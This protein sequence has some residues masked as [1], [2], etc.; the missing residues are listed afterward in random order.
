M[1]LIKKKS[2]V[3]DE[4]PTSSMADIAF[5]LL[6]FFLVTTIFDRDQGLQVVLPE[7][8]DAEIDVPPDNLLFL[9]VQ[10]NGSIVVRRGESPQTQTITH[11]QVQG[12]VRQAL[13]ANPEVIAAV[14]THPEARYEDMT[15]V[16]DGIQLAGARRFVLQQLQD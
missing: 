2:K 11:R 8:E 5:L 1:P 14:Q 4:I 6:I 9:L 7:R 13:Q 16:L 12:V 3:S 10:P 15:N